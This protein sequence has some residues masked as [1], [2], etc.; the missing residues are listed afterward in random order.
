MTS[1][2]NSPPNL[3]PTY[4]I[5]FSEKFQYFDVFSFAENEI[6]ADEERKSK[7]EKQFWH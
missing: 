5:N 1:Q 2:Y 3:G 6:V 7:R 4:A